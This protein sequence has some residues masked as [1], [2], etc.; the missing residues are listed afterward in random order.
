MSYQEQCDYFTKEFVKRYK[1]LIDD[2]EKKFN[3]PL[4]HVIATVTTIIITDTNCR[5][6]GINNFIDRVILKLFE[7][8]IAQEPGEKK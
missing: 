2:Y 5:K 7:Y 4:D 8:K 3:K 1:G 6:N